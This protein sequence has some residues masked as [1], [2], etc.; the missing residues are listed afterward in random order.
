MSRLIRPAGRVL[1]WVAASAAS[2]RA[3][4]AVV[5]EHS[6]YVHP[7]AQGRGIGAVLLQALIASTETAGIW[8]IQ[9][10]IF[11]GQNSGVC[12]VADGRISHVPP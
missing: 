1:A 11:H 8:T 4:Y 6:V 5:V 9:S 12:P 2:T 10:G 3:V 7:E